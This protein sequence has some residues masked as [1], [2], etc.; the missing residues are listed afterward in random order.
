MRLNRIINKILTR[1]IFLNRTAATFTDRDETV[2]KIFP[3]LI[4]MSLPL[5][6][7]IVENFQCLV[8]IIEHVIYGYSYLNSLE[9]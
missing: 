2:A 4:S 3:H 1:F 5:K 8:Y 9:K 6:S 7:L